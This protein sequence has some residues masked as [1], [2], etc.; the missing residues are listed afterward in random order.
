MQPG[1]VYHQLLTV[2]LLTDEVA[3]LHV[4]QNQF[5]AGLCD[6]IKYKLCHMSYYQADQ[7]IP[8][9]DVYDYGLWDLNRILVGIGRSPAELLP[10]PFPQQQ[11]G[12]RT[13]NSLLQAEQYDA[14]EM[15][16]LVNEQRAMFNPEQT[17][18]FDAVLESVTNNQGY[19]FFIHTAG[20]CGKTFLCNTIATKVRRRGQMVLWIA[21]SRIVALLLDGERTS[22]SCFKIPLS[23]NKDFMAGLKWNS[24]MFPVI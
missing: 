16:T 10:M 8:E 2:I 21:S 11:W 12:H 22:H 18:A 23:I 20:G 17:A 9:D 13:P 14:D 6:D 7:E 5:K 24:Y 19:L 15:A 3:E 1:V 4:L